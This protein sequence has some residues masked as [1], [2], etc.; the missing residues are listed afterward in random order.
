MSV[1]WL[2]TTFF[3]LG[4]S[5]FVPRTANTS[6]R[7]LCCV[8]HVFVGPAPCNDDDDDD[9]DDDVLHDCGYLPCSWM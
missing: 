5:A 7:M 3:P 4:C 8:L 2:Q 1:W 6:L 9:G